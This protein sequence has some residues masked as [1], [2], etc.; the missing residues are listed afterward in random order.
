MKQTSVIHSVDTELIYAA[1]FCHFPSNT[2]YSVLIPSVPGLLNLFLFCDSSLKKGVSM[3]P[4]WW[5]GYIRYVE[6][7]GRMRSSLG[8][9]CR[10]SILH[11]DNQSL[12]W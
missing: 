1:F 10:K 6:L 7:A 4:C 8:F 5:I 9:R 2:K 12:L 3:R 11:T